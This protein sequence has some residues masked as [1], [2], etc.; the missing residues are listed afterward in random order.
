MQYRFLFVIRPS[1][2]PDGALDTVW[3]SSKGGVDLAVNFAAEVRR[4]GYNPETLKHSQMVFMNPL[5]EVQSK[6]SIRSIS[7]PVPERDLAA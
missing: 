6:I 3:V 7:N 1:D 5:P 2:W 4:R